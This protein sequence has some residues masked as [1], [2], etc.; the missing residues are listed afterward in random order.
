[1][2]SESVDIAEQ[3]PGV[4]GCQELPVR[5]EIDGPQAGQLGSVPCGQILQDEEVVELSPAGYIVSLTQRT[6]L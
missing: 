1:M 3:L 4:G 6:G 2:T 5:Q